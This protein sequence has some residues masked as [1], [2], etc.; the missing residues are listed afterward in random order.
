[1]QK[2]AIDYYLYRNLSKDPKSSPIL[3][4]S[5]DLF[6]D[7][8]LHKNKIIKKLTCPKIRR[9]INDKC[10]DDHYLMLNKHKEKCCYKIRTKKKI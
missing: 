1:L 2:S 7:I 6:L 10:N 9:P 8:K 4:S 3:N 5:N